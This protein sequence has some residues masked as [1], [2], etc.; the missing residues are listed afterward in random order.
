MAQKESAATISRNDLMLH[1][2][3]AWLILRMAFPTIIP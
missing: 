3:I 2:P 1:S